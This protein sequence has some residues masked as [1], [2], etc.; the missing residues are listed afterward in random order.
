M[1]PMH[2]KKLLLAISL[3]ASSDKYIRNTI[4]GYDLKNIKIF[5][6][7]LLFDTKTNKALIQVY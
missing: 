1:Y 5:K 3:N 6:H 7:L 2:K 4:M